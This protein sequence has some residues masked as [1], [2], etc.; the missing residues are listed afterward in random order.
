LRRF[1]AQLD[2]VHCGSALDLVFFDSVDV[3][4]PGDRADRQLYG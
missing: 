4:V 2:I 3:P 1:R